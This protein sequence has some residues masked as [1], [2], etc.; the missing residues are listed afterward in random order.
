MHTQVRGI[1]DTSISA[2]SAGPCKDF[3][4]H[5]VLISD[6]FQRQR[7]MVVIVILIDGDIF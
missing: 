2:V 3:F 6:L 1:E 5:F 4:F 7:F